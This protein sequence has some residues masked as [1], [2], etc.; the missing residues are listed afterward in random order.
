M[1]DADYGRW[2]SLGQAHQN[3]GRSIDAMLCYRQALRRRSS[4]V[5]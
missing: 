2:L 1:I 4:G 3:A 5:G